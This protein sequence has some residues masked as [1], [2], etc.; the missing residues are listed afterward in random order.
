MGG[1]PEVVKETVTGLLVRPRDETG[2]ASAVLSLAADPGQRERM[3]KAAREHAHQFSLARMVEK[4][5]S[6]YEDLIR[7]K[8]LDA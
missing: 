2:I 5:E 8:R 4:I 6:L 7:E 3:G 1:I